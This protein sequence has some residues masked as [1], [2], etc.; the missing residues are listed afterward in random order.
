MKSRLYEFA[1]V[2]QTMR[3]CQKTYHAL[4]KQ[5]AE[6]QETISAL[7]KSKEAERVVDWWLKQLALHGEQES[8]FPE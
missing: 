4:R 3:T 1:D 2:V 8:L 5:R 7:V 6:A